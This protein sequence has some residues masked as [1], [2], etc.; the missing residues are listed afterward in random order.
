M[1]VRK[2]PYTNAV[3]RFYIS[4]PDM[5]PRSPPLVTFSTDIF[6]PLITPLS[7]QGYA[8]DLQDNGTS[9][10]S[11][12]EH[13]PPGGF[14]LRHGFPDW[15]GRRGAQR[16]VGGSPRT[17]P[18]QTGKTAASTPESR[19]TPAGDMPGYMRSGPEGVS[20]YDVLRYMR[21]VFDDEE[22]LD[23]VGLQAAGNVG[24]WY[25]WRTHRKAQGKVF[26][27][28]EEAEEQSAA[29]GVRHPGSWDWDGVWEDR[30]KAGITGSLSE[31]VL[32][33]GASGADDVIRFQAMEDVDIE[34]VKDNLIRTLG[35]SR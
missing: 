20:T 13:L 5:Y 28:D 18:P 17:P 10:V 15:F 9:G 7:N 12:V 33:G 26:E 6:H 16:G 27:G 24:A 1:F 34:T 14:S 2:G 31:P 30:V 32:Y 29:D 3:L 11:N 22:A 4:F 35:I 23:G 19:A 25:A 8:A 21:S